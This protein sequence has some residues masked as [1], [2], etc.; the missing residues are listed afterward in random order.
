MY[1][2]CVSMDPL[3][4]TGER[5]CMWALDETQLWCSRGRQPAGASGTP[6]SSRVTKRHFNDGLRVS[7]HQLLSH[8]SATGGPQS[9]W[10]AALTTDWQLGGFI[11]WG[12]RS[13]KFLKSTVIYLFLLSIYYLSYF[14]YFFFN[15]L[16]SIAC[17]FSRHNFS[18][19]NILRGKTN[20]ANLTERSPLLRFS[21]DDRWVP[22]LHNTLLCPS[23]NK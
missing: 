5:V 2:Y 19:V 14:S 6:S 22:A 15:S 23:L 17:F 18:A 10:Q 21:Q 4:E 13:W 12:Q 8:L 7:S 11:I 1:I 20:S 3:W 16:L 9:H